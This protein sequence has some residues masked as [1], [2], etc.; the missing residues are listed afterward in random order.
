MI[1]RY[2]ESKLPIGGAIAPLLLQNPESD[3][4]PQSTNQVIPAETWNN[5]YWE[6]RVNLQH[7]AYITIAKQNVILPPLDGINLWLKADA[8]TCTSS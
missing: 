7:G 8:G 1:V 6:F 3:T 4:F 2:P 5:G